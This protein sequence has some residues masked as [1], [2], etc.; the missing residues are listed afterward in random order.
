MRFFTLEQ[1]KLHCRVDNDDE[2][3]LLEIYAS[4]AERMC[5][6]KIKRKIF[7]DV[8]EMQT[9]LVSSGAALRSTLAEYDADMAILAVD[10]DRVLRINRV[11]RLNSD[12]AEIY[13]VEHGIVINDSIRA[14]A[15]LMLGHLYRNREQNVT[16]QGEVAQPL[17]TGFDEILNPYVWELAE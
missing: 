2:D 10:G 1:A 14:A 4:A 16:G 17:V 7:M 3:Q 9:A 6:Q 5:E 11:S 15:A 13:M 8:E 12:L